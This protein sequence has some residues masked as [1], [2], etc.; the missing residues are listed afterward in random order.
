[1]SNHVEPFDASLDSWRYLELNL[2]DPLHGFPPCAPTCT[3]TEIWLYYNLPDYAEFLLAHSTALTLVAGSVT[4]GLLVAGLV[5][6]KTA[7][8]R[9]T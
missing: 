3:N 5:W 1:M 2:T 6:T 4:L 8:R 7:E 9:P